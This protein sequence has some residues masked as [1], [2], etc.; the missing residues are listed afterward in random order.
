[1]S[2]EEYCERYLENRIIDLKRELTAEEVKII[3]K[4]EVKI[5]NSLYNGAEYEKLKT[6]R[7]NLNK[8]KIVLI[9]FFLILL[10]F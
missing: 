5:E 1:M 7:E 6:A 3:E 10:M 2:L 8:D 4:L 9:W